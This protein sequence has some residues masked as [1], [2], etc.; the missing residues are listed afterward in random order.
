MKLSHVSLIVTNL[1]WPR[2]CYDWRRHNFCPSI[3]VHD[4][5]PDL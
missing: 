2:I 1:R 3:L 5:S 4:L